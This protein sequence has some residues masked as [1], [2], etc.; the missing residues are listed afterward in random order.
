MSLR[1]TQEQFEA[2]QARRGIP[3]HAGYVPLSTHSSKIGPSDVP[4]PDQGKESDLQ[5]KIERYCRDHGYYFFHD[6]SR[7][8][9]AK[10]HPDLV[11]AI[12]HRTLWLELKSAQGRLSSEQRQVRLQL[13]QLGQEWHE[14]RSFKQFLTIINN[15]G[16][17][18]GATS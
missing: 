16:S 17:N 6:R 3:K 9:N 12:H 8:D 2:Y 1:W 13:L 5:A 4:K 14:V 7:G 11:I 15:D 10:G 18:D